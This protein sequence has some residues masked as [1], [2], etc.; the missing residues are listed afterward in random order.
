MRASKGTPASAET[1]ISC[2][3]LNEAGG[4]VHAPAVPAASAAVA[5]DLEEPTIVVNADCRLVTARKAV[6]SGEELVRPEP[7]ASRIGLDC[8]V[9]PNSLMG[10][11]ILTGEQ[12]C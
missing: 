5:Q 11:S 9:E 12:D 7:I 6:V 1:K 8:G 3:H 2:N 4:R 10:T